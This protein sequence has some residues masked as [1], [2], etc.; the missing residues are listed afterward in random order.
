MRQYFH[1]FSKKIPLLLVIALGIAAVCFLSVTASDSLG[2]ERLQNGELQ[3]S[4]L[5]DPAF[6]QEEYEWLL[7][8]QFD[9]YESMTVSQ[10]QSRVWRETDT[11]RD[12][13]LL[14]RFSKS[15]AFYQMRDVDPVASFY[16]YIL[17]PLTAETW[18]T[19]SFGNYART[20]FPGASDQAVFEFVYSFTILDAD[21]LTVRDY[22]D[23]RAGVAEGLKQ[24][25]TGKTR[26]ELADDNLM[27]EY[28]AA[29]TEA[30]AKQWN[31]DRLWVTV[32]YV[33]QPLNPDTENDTGGS[34]Q[35]FSESDP[36][37]FPPGTPEDYRSLLELK[38]ADYSDMS[39]ADFNLILLDWA[40]EDYERM[41]RISEDTRLQE[42]PADLTDEERSFVTLTVRL[43]GTENGK[44]V[45]SNYT[46]RPEADPDYSENLPERTGE[47][48]LSSSW[49]DLYYQLTYHIPDKTALTVGERDRQVG[50][51]IQAIRDF[52]EN[53]SI[54]ALIY[55]K[56]EEVAQGLS[57]L[58]TQYSSQKLTIT[59][60]GDQIH[61]EKMKE[62]RSNPDDD[63]LLRS[64]LTTD[65]QQKTVADFNA[66]LASTPDELTIL[67]DA[68]AQRVETF[69]P[70]DEAYEFLTV[71]LQA[72]L[73]ELYCEE[74]NETPGWAINLVKEERPCPER[75]PLGETI[76]NFQFYAWGSLDYIISSPDHLTVAQRDR[77]L[78]RFQAELSAYTDSLSEADITADNF[79][80]T[81]KNKA[82]QLAAALST[83]E[84]QLFFDLG[85]MDIMVDG[86]D[87][88]R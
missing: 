67:L 27:Q 35:A 81:L 3:N 28:L 33:F 21:S 1:G 80:T 30:L 44:Y 38:T 84:M 86:T 41:E 7:A 14:E 31:S 63:T 56:K 37:E 68:Y 53:T 39:L 46:G 78:Q 51:L 66:S 16:F 70:E 9:D 23:A 47:S 62:P 20:D 64:F 61:F 12:R 34:S 22:A 13:E 15:N 40:N 29:Q 54:E 24:M 52:W 19:R 72:S 75:T 11:P 76:Y 10:Y 59:I 2:N 45:Q 65:Y 74:F 87:L 57:E 43:S 60:S 6:S 42:F 77:T 73:T 32:E 71:T 17:E 88:S 83:N 58:A 69:S 5:P 50:G 36:R 82:A 18:Q 49:C 8:L 85:G 26:K 55:M 25:L 4:G 79:R 48:A